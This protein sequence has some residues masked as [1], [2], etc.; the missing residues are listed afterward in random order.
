MN[1]PIVVIGSGIVGS[2]IA[3]E[4]QS[5]GATTILVERDVEPQGASA[6]SFA[7]LSAF[8]EPLRDVYLHKSL[9]MV[10]WR[11][12]TK[13]Y[14]DDLRVRWDGEIRWAESSD[15]A[16]KLRTQIEKAHSRGYPVRSISAEEIRRRF[17]ASAPGDILAASWV[18]EDG[19]PDPVRAI[20]VLRGEFAELGGT[21][22]VGRASLLFDDPRVCVRVGEDRID[23]SSVVVA[24]GAESGGLLERF[25]WEL[26]MDPSPGLLVL[27]EPTDPL[28]TGTVYVT[29]ASGV[30]IHLRQRA[31]AGS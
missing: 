21:I 7:S 23:A 6:F 12:W 10:R 31:D 25:G 4:P 1:G 8:D 3:F 17:P 16:D 14:R 2:A 30:R 20:D 27:T 11:E 13:R 18:P 28:V 19:Q 15:G 26:P 5:R 22:L 24:A 29:P 9:G